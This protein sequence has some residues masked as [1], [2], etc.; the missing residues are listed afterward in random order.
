MIDDP[1]DYKIEVVI[2]IPPKNRDK[3]DLLENIIKQY[4]QYGVVIN[5][6]EPHE[7]RGFV[8]FERCGHHLGLPCEL[9]EKVEVALDAQRSPAT[10]DIR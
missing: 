10:L 5:K 9:L 4:L 2:T 7:E 8:R 1:R 3:A 6:G